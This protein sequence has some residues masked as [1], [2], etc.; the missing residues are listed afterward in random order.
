MLTT[1]TVHCLFMSFECILL[2][3]LYILI[4]RVFGYIKI[5]LEESP[6]CNWLDPVWIRQPVQCIL[7]HLTLYCKGRCEIIHYVV[8]FHFRCVIRLKTHIL[9]KDYIACISGHIANW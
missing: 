5:F 6:V 3:C 1:D 8:N 7:M 9:E 2:I 4:L